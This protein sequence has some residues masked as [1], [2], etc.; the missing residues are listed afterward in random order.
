MI[1]KKQAQTYTFFASESAVRFRNR[2]YGNLPLPGTGIVI[3]GIRELLKLN[4]SAPFRRLPSRIRNQ[5]AG[6]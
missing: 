6:S 3:A 2:H 1:K 5:P 4:S